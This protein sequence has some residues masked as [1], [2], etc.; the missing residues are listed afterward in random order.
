MCAD[1]LEKNTLGGFFLCAACDF[2]LSTCGALSDKETQTKR[3]NYRHI[4][5]DIK[6]ILREEEMLRF[7]TY[8]F[9]ARFL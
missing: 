1:N 7:G 4:Y 9:L 2:H 8:W 3:G 6:Y 5:C